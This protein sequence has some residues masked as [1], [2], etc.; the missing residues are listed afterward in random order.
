MVHAG[1]SGPSPCGANRPIPAF[2][3]C[4]VIGKA[5]LLPSRCVMVLV[6][7]VAVFPSYPRELKGQFK[8]LTASFFPNV[9][10]F[11][12][13]SVTRDRLRFMTEGAKSALRS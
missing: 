1:F 11:S 3:G 5:R 2:V 8:L 6:I 7:W 10:L 13:P 4:W 9:Q 12:N